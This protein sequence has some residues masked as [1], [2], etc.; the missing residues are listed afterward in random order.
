MHRPRPATGS[1]RAPND[2]DRTH[3]RAEPGLKVCRTGF[4]DV[5]DLD[6][7]G[8]RLGSHFSGA[9][10]PWFR[11]DATSRKGGSGAALQPG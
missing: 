1:R 10:G 3:D 6:L 9:L 8:R 5:P 7:D 2:A 4:M 11:P